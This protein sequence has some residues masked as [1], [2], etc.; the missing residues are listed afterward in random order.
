MS[1]DVTVEIL[2]STCRSQRP[3]RSTAA[4]TSASSSGRKPVRFAIRASMSGSSPA[5]VC[6]GVSEARAAIDEREFPAA[7]RALLIRGTLVDLEGRGVEHDA[8]VLQGAARR[9]EAAGDVLTD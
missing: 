5:P 2:H 1:V 3:S 4:R 8:V 7:A 9:D 6:L